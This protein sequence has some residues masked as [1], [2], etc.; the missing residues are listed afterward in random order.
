MAISPTYP[1]V[2]V[3]ET[4]AV[5]HVVT[6][7]TTNLTAVLGDY[8]RGPVGEAV[9]V[10]SMAQFTSVY[11]E[12]ETGS[13]LAAYAVSQFFLNGG[14]GAWIVRLD[15]GAT[16][17]TWT[18]DLPAAPGAPQFLATASSPGAWG[19]AIVPRFRSSGPAT[20]AS[21]THVDLVVSPVV[22][23]P[24]PRSAPPPLEVIA[25]VPLFQADGR[26]PMDPG[27]IAALISDQSSYVTLTAQD[28]AASPPASPPSSPP[29]S[30]P[31]PAAGVDGAWTASGPGSLSAAVSSA[32]AEGGPLDQIA[33][34]VFNIMC[35]P[36]AA[37]SA[38]GV[39]GDVF[40][41]ASE[42]C[43]QRQAFLL[44]DPPPPAA[45]I[46]EPGIQQGAL[47]IDNVGSRGTAGLIAACPTGAEN[48]AAATY[49]PWL[50]ISDPVT[51]LPRHVPPSGT[52]AGLYAATDT[53]RGVWKA[54]AGTEAG[55]RGIIGLADTT[56]SDVANGEL[57]VSGI[58]CLRT[59]PIY[60]TVVWGSR[61][62]AGADVIGSPFKYVPVRR[63]ADFIEQSLQQ[64]LR[65]A[66]FE[67][68]A[69]PLWSSI[70]L[71]VTAFMSGLYGAGAFAGA[72]AA[73]AYTVSVS[74]SPT[75]QLAGIVN[76]A[77]GF[78]PVD[79]AEFVMLNIQ[80][81]AATAAS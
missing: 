26:T 17:A 10:S 33:P 15:S 32:L 81:N 41:K 54:P 57:N 11:G 68:N 34:N 3:S 49:Y 39:P 29:S 40:A 43:E 48:V 44:F 45:A 72:S 63:T 77:V 19:N 22:T 2:Y 56:I 60:N 67:P 51:G 66:V 7:A 75:E 25:N 4:A 55:V 52:I 71:E 30:P 46:G 42:F 59:F 61:T 31:A 12:L 21:T 5:P 37:G 38:P 24:P 14:I 65:W 70:L 13:S 73:Q 18:L 6:P 47:T 50:I 76:V 58:N 78:T 69:A 64:S 8:P 9:L 80:I 35:V 27:V 74:A 53:A 79:P 28:A 36:E 16:P 1:G 62:L 23:S 20:P